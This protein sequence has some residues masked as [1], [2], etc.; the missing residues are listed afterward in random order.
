MASFIAPIPLLSAN[1]RPYL[2]PTPRTVRTI[3]TTR[4]KR[5]W[6]ACVHCASADVAGTAAKREEIS[7]L[8]EYLPEGA[9]RASYEWNGHEISYIRRY[10]EPTTPAV[11]LVHGFG[12]NALHWRSALRALLSSTGYCGDVYAIDLLGFG[13]SDKPPLE[14]SID[15][16]RDQVS[17]FIASLPPAQEVILVGNSIGSLT[18]LAATANNNNS[19]VRA[20]ALMNCAGGLVSFRESEVSLPV[21]LLI[22]AINAVLFNPVV[23]GWLF[24]WIR[25]PKNLRNVRHRIRISIFQCTY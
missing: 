17:A 12:G 6:R 20:L 13:N 23:G 14:Y 4:T 18:C 11:V 8:P 25:T 10:G 3:R 22:R 15:L 9:Q 16:W 21:K 2:S 7:N 1:V 19:S 24:R 5:T